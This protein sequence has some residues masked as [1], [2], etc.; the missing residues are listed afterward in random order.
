[1]KIPK[2]HN[3]SHAFEG[4]TASA[5]SFCLSLYNVSYASSLISSWLTFIFDGRAGHLVIHRL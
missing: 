1:M 4:T 5:S 2:P 3:F